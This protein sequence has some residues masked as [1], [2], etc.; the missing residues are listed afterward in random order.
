[1]ITGDARQ[2][3]DTVGA[4]LGIDEVFA[5]VL[6]EDKDKAVIELKQRGLSVA[7]DG[8]GVND[9]PALARADSVSPS[10]PAPTSPSNRPVSCSPPATPAASRASSGSRGPATARCSRTWGGRPATT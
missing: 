2:A 7:M 1:M 4:E 3:A 8:D 5:E 6:P 9:A 10:G